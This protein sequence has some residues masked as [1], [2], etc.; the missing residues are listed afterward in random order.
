MKKLL[1]IAA[2]AT[3]STSLMAAEQP[4]STGATA[5]AASSPLSLATPVIG[6]VTVAGAV[7][8]GAAVVAAGV[9]ASNSGG[10]GGHDSNPGTGGTT[11]TT[12]TTR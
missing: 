7:G 5:P 9:A 1:M 12:G 4:A 3:L 10:G 8:I 11:G 6:G 2:M